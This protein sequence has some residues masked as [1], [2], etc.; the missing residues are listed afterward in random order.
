[1]SDILDL[2]GKVTLIYRIVRNIGNRPMTGMYVC[3]G[4]EIDIVMP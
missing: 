2:D 3:R 4:E 1:M